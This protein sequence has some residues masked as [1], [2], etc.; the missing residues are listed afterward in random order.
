[1]SPGE[2][3]A[4]VFELSE[5]TKELFLDGLRARHPHLNDDEIRRLAVQIRAKRR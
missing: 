2:R 5:M 3:L 1:M 4:K